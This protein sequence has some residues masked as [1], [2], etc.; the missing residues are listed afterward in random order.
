MKNQKKFLNQKNKPE[1]E[2]TRKRKFMNR[3]KQKIEDEETAKHQK[4]WFST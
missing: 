4:L 2:Q 3:I 1:T